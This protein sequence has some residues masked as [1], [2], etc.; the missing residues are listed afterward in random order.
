MLENPNKSNI[1][2]IRRI[3]RLSGWMRMAIPGKQGGYFGGRRMSAAVRSVAPS[4]VNSP[5]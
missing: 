4:R 3:L 2:S 5:V 1:M